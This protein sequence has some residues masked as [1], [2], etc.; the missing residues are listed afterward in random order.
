[1]NERGGIGP[2][3]QLVAGPYRFGRRERAAVVWAPAIRRGHS[4]FHLRDLDF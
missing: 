4:P 1:V 2:A 3:Q